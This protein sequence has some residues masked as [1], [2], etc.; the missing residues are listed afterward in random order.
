M[1]E[2]QNALSSVQQPSY[3]ARICRRDGP[4]VEEAMA[5]ATLV[6]DGARLD[7][8][9]IE[10]SYAF[11]RP[12]LL[13]RLRDDEV[14]R[15]IDLQSLRF[16]GAKYLETGSLSRLPYAPSRPIT[17]GE[18]DAKQADELARGGLAFAQDRGTDIYLAPTVPLFD[19]DTAGWL[20]HADTLLGAAC[21][22]NG[23]GEIERKPMIAV[24][25]PGARALTQVDQLIRRLLDQPVVGVYIQP[26]RL[27]P[28]TDSLEKLARFVQF[29]AA[30]RDA[31]FEVIVGRV[32]AFGLVLQALG[33]RAFDSGLGQAEAHDVATLNRR[34]TEA[35]KR[36]RAS[37]KGGGPQSR[38]YLEPLKTTVSPR[39]AAA[40]LSSESVRGR[41]A[42]T[43]GCCRF[44][45][46]S[47]L[48]G[49][50]RSHYLYVRRHEVDSMRKLSIA[51][52]RLHQV[53]TQ[54][55][56]ARDL[57]ATVRRALDEQSA[58]HL[59]LGHLDVWLGLLAR[60]QELALAS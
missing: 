54:L 30:I 23:A 51:A 3:F 58:P 20:R 43:L 33:I 15:F 35:E 19:V 46:L 48:P 37:G 10:A 42:C 44:R 32:G 18:F 25:A 16:A 57:G 1:A 34:I 49:R 56:A 14:P 4:A 26:L 55:R 24:I 52:M 17:L 2:P 39:V 28:V 5:A 41:F 45:A 38:V 27:N 11:D 31:G 50:A 22:H 8:A 60:E 13:K 21:A 12:P 6:S 36:R 7:G 59:R 47:D 53:E 29:A 9:V 40:I